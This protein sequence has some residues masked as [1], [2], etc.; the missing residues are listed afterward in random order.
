MGDSLAVDVVA[1]WG[2]QPR[3]KLSYTSFGD[4]FGINSIYFPITKKTVWDG[5]QLKPIPNPDQP[6]LEINLILLFF[7]TK[8]K[9]L[10]NGE[11]ENTIPY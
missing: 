11:S 1:T 2:Q 3:A 7:C 6:L 8:K 4:K 9:S 5:S 10:Q